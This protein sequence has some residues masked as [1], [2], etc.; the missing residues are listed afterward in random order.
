M[1][2]FHK[3]L[4]AYPPATMPQNAKWHLWTGI[5]EPAEQPKPQAQPPLQM[6]ADYADAEEKT[7]A[8]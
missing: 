7:K 8:S 2:Y 6:A 5:I 4:Q 1:S 3:P